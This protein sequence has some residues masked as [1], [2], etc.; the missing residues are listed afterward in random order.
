MEV[1][2]IIMAIGYL[3][4]CNPLIFVTL[5]ALLAIPVTIGIV[6]YI[7]GIEIPTFSRGRRGS[8]RRKSKGLLQT[9]F[10][11]QARTQRRNGHPRGARSSLLGS[12]RK[13]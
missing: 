4:I 5:L 3:I 2:V 9:I 8:Y 7:K 6:L 13:R 12:N 10:D 11:D 1:I